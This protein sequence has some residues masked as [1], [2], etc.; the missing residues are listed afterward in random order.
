MEF[1]SSTYC[2]TCLNDAVTIDVWLDNP[3]IGAVQVLF[4]TANGTAL[5]GVNYAK[6]FGVLS[7]PGGGVREEFFSIPILDDRQTEVPVTVNL[8]LSEPDGALLGD[9]SSAVLTIYPFSPVPEPGTMTL[10]ALGLAAFAPVV[11]R[12]KVRV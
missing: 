5:A 4:Q 10:L 7:F 6:R 8:S 2:T 9:P 11:R 3:S 12:Y 1:G